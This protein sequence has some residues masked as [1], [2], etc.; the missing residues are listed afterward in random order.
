[1]K[2]L[3]NYHDKRDTVDDIVDLIFFLTKE[4]VDKTIIFLCRKVIKI[5]IV[6]NTDLYMKKLYCIFIYIY[7]SSVYIYKYTI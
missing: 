7:R 6:I 2:N 3:I 4:H 5:K 1:M